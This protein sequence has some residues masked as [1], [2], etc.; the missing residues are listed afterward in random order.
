VVGTPSVVTLPLQ[1]RKAAKP[2]T[3]HIDKVKPYFAETPESWLIE[4]P[5]KEAVETTEQTE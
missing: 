4:G 1:Q 2:F 3:V 5:K